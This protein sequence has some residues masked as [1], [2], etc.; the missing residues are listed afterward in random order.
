MKY[1]NKGQYSYQHAVIDV[2]LLR[3][4][5][6]LLH[7]VGGRLAGIGLVVGGGGVASPRVIVV[8]SRIRRRH[9]RCV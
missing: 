9:G 8:G 7:G 3:R 1:M 4:V 5:L 2:K 6:L